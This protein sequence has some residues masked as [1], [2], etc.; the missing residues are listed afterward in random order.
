MQ[1]LR[2]PGY[3]A[4]VVV[5]KEHKR[6]AE[7]G[8]SQ[9]ELSDR[10]VTRMQPKLVCN[11]Q[12]RR[13]VILD[14][15]LL[16]SSR[17]LMAGFSG[18][19]PSSARCVTGNGRGR[20]H[21]CC[22]LAEH[23]TGVEQAEATEVSG[24]AGCVGDATEVAAGGGRLGGTREVYDEDDDDLEQALVEE[25]TK[26]D[27]TGITEWELD[28]CSRPI[29]DS[30]GKKMWELLVCDSTRQLEHAEYFPN[31]KVNSVTLREALVKMMEKTG[32]SKPQKV[33]FFRSQV[34]TIISKACAELD[35]QPVPSQRCL[36]LVRWLEERSENV[37]KNEPGY[38][39]GATPALFFEQPIPQDLPGT[40]RGEQWAFVQLPLSGVME[41]MAAVERGQVFGSVFGL[42]KLGLNLSD[43][44]MI[45]GVAVASTRA[46][47]LSAW[48]NALELAAIQ[49][50]LPKACLVL[51]TGV[52]DRWRYAFFRRSRQ[53][54]KEAMAWEAAKQAVGGLH[55]LAVQRQ[56]DAEE[57]TG[58]WLLQD[59]RPPQI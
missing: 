14:R 49:V 40:L 12:R 6:P 15:P 11:D 55:F 21:V 2:P 58:F 16:H 35:I 50:D 26:R 32:A 52:A 7:T 20:V 53:A 36:T 29:V 51:N 9:R 17:V 5:K 48:T 30:R 43:D 19:G 18:P 3:T 22:S 1:T 47:P 13:M 46:T 45:P 27:L 56:L 44:V 28:F 57:C 24:G 23:S 25:T 8:C 33:R 34:Q 59:I 54:D 4:S 37:Y 41:E 38:E 42:E 10:N 39:A 31:N